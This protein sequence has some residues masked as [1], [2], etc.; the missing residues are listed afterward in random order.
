MLLS[1]QRGN[2]I[3][4]KCYTEIW[5]ATRPLTAETVARQQHENNKLLYLQHQK[6]NVLIVIELQPYP[7]SDLA[8]Q[9]I[10]RF[11]I[12]VTTANVS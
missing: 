6:L 7:R 11:I 5:H 8:N 1:S 4:K 9:M 12:Y 2:V 3:C 10:L